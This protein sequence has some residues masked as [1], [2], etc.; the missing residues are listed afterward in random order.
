MPLAR[1]LMLLL[2]FVGLTAAPLR[3]EEEPATEAPAQIR[4]QTWLTLAP[5][6]ARGRRPFNP[7][8]TFERYLLDPRA[9]VPREGDALQG[10]SGQATWTKAAA[11][12]RGGVGGEIAWAYARLSSKTRRVMM[13]DLRGGA[14]L[15]VNGTPHVGSIYG[16]EFQVPVLL[17]EGDNDLYVRGVRGSFSLAL[18]TPPHAVFVAPYRQTMPDL[19][20][21]E[22]VDTVA[23]LLVV[24]ASPEPLA[25]ISLVCPGNAWLEPTVSPLPLPLVPLGV[26]QLR[27]P[28]RSRAGKTAPREPGPVSLE[29]RLAGAGSEGAPSAP[30]TLDV[31]A[32]TEPLLQTFVSD[33]DDSVQRFGVRRPA[34]G[35][36]E[37]PMGL[38]LTLHGAGVEPRGQVASY[39]PKPDFWIV[40]PTNRDRF[41]FDWQDWGRDDAYEVLEQALR[42]SG[43]DRRRV[44]LTGHSMGG[45]GTWHLAANDP[46]GFAAIAPSA[47]WISF[48]T[49]PGPRPAARLREVWHAADAASDT[50]AL[51]DNLVQMPTYILHGTQDDNVPVEQAREMEKRLVEA[52]GAPR[53]HYEEGQGHWWDG[54]PEPGAQ[55]VDWPGIFELFRE[56]VLPAVPDEIR[57]TTVGPHVDARHFW[58]AVLGQLE[59]GKPS[60]VTARYD[61]QARHLT[62]TTVNVRSLHLTHPAA[63]EH[64]TLDGETFHGARAARSTWRRQSG[65]WEP[66]TAPACD[67]AGRP[68]EVEGGPFKWAWRN[69]FVMVHG[70]HGPE[71]MTQALLEQARF[72]AQRWTY[73][74][75][76]RALLISDDTYMAGADAVQLLGR[77]VIY[78]GN[79]STNG[80][81]AAEGSS[82]VSVLPGVLRFGAVTAI[83]ADLGACFTLPQVHASPHGVVGS[84]G[85]AGS[86]LGF[87][88]LP[89]T[90]G[91]G[92][93]DHVAYDARILSKGDDGV[94]SAGWWPLGSRDGRGL[95][96]RRQPPK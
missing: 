20:V 73:R 54:N 17:R 80:A 48:D 70:T 5:V 92:W 96:V 3:A 91:V 46:D 84:T 13:A 6:D 55:C 83:G 8:A 64:L 1:R 25:G 27:L 66:R 59:R 37:R 74:A 77:G 29:I 18:S 2:A 75:N 79:P 34:P 62:A 86:R 35:G 67:P 93:P 23:G 78:Y 94:V 58:V 69:R 65:G 39:A 31:R 50:P 28:L 81:L 15:F 53:V 63:R 11:D 57:F 43:V 90:S 21:G 22:P 33:I 16:D 12:E 71:G 51:L 36:T 10:S 24:N 32:D 7:D 19:V 9:P 56:T 89:F 87:T 52:G 49:Y 60:R 82:G 47:G 14:A 4:V 30:L 95:R 42:L 76:G 88:L 40:A 85:V 38:V 68:L 41:G 61:P 26:L 45:H 72:D 44:Y